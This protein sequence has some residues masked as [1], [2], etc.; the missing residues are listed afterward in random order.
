MIT[1]RTSILAGV[2]S[3]LALVW[4]QMAAGVWNAARR[5]P[6]YTR[7]QRVGIAVLVPP[8]ALVWILLLG[9]RE[10]GRRAVGMVLD[11]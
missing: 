4:V 9:I 11:K 8:I 5:D 2:L 7:W 10:L 3:L 1:P 6:A